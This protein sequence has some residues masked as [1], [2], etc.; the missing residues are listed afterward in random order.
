MSARAG[1]ISFLAG[2]VFAVGL[3]LAGMTRPEKVVAFLDVGGAWDPALGFVMGG[4]IAVHAVAYALQRRWSTPLHA[5]MWHL[6]TRK[7][8]DGRLVGGAAIF[9]V[10][11]GLSGFC[12]GPAV[13]SLGTAAPSVLVFVGA[14]MVGILLE[15]VASAPRKA[16]RA[17][18]DNPEEALA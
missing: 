9:G 10:G 16:P 4:A 12:P 3:A 15:R 2:A 6:P 13:A 11:W 17:D 14:M 1:G 18:D 5:P 8:V 7:D